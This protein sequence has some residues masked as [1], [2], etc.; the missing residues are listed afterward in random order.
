[1]LYS[2]LLES[3]NGARFPEVNLKKRTEEGRNSIRRRWGMGAGGLLKVV[4][5]W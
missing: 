4:E 3:S 2:S 1:M 5:G